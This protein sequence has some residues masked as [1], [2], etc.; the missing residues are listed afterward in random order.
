MGLSTAIVPLEFLL[1]SSDHST[2]KDVTAAVSNVGVNLGC[3]TTPQG[4]RDYIGR[5][6]VDGLILDLEVG[7]ALDVINS[8]RGGN[9]NRRAFI[10]ACVANKTDSAAALKGGANAL[11]ERPLTQASISS[12]IRAFKGIIVCE[13]RHYFRHAVMVPVVLLAG[14][15]KHRAIMENI[16]EG[17]MAVRLPRTLATSTHVDFSFEL[18]FGPRIPGTGRVAWSNREGLMGV[19]FLVMDPG[20]RK[21]LLS[22]LRDRMPSA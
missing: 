2:L 15:A 11:L 4:A 6:K 8:V 7:T 19:E 1:V 3:T 18:P 17:G 20:A 9:A 12:G 22:W 10:F 14:D 21:I 13:R 5:H 16:S